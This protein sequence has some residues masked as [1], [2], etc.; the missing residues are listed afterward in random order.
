MLRDPRTAPAVAHGSVSAGTG[1]D[2]GE[3]ARGSGR[4]TEP[5]PEDA[6]PSTTSG[7]FAVW[8][9]RWFLRALVIRNLKVKYQRSLLGFVWTIVNPLIT[10]AILVA[11]FSQVVRIAVPDY[12]AFLV[13]GY[14]VWHS[15]LQTLNTG[16]YILAEH[17]RLTRSV[18][19]PNEILV[20]SAAL[21]RLLEFAAEMTLIVAVLV[22]FH[23][24]TVP[25]S[26]AL[27]PVLVATQLLLVVG[28]A[29]PIATLSAFYYDVQ[30]ALPIALTTLFYLSPVFYPASMVPDAV[31][32]LYYLNPFAG[33]LTLYHAV[34][35]E[36]V[37]PPLAAL[38]GMAAASAA[39]AVLGYAVF[40]RY[41]PVFAEIV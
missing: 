9:F 24:G 11:V 3:R 28:L 22:F 37:M 15:A 33:L 41:A 30:H 14:F 4:G 6:P 16:T 40:R 8:R 2:H 7:L 31:R 13:S 5:G 34:L 10:A 19:F 20:L 32:P 26:L 18:A 27:L 35:Y 17:A 39:I 25:A 23:H 1:P 29:L 36:G 12:W 38:A 21:S